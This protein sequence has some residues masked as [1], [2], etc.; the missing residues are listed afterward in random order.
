MRPFG[1]DKISEA[2]RLVKAFPQPLI[3]TLLG[4][5]PDLV[6]LARTPFFLGLIAEFGS[7]QRRLP[8]DQ[9]ELFEAYL[10]SRMGSLSLQVDERSSVGIAQA[11]LAAENM[12]H[13]LQTSRFGL[14]GAARYARS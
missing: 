5:R 10:L 8:N 14:E 6:P 4:S 2:L 11:I 1:E 3:G 13:F 12:A 7:S 9:I